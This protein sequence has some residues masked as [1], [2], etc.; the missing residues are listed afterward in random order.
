MHHGY[1]DARAFLDGGGEHKPPIHMRPHRHG[2]TASAT[3]TV[4]ISDPS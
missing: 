1:G 2:A 4:G 3:P